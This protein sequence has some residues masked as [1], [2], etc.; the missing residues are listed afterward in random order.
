[1]VDVEKLSD[2]EL[3]DQLTKHG[4][5]PGP[6]LPS[7]R[8]V[9]EKKLLQILN[10][11]PSKPTV[12]KTTGDLELFSENDE[13]Y[14]SDS[15]LEP[16]SLEMTSEKAQEDGKVSNTIDVN[17]L[18]IEVDT[19]LTEP[20]IHGQVEMKGSNSP[21]GKMRHRFLHNKVPESTF[22]GEYELIIYTPDPR[23]PFG[24][25]PFEKKLIKEEVP[26]AQPDEPK[27]E[28]VTPP[29]QM[30]TQVA[31]EE[32]AEEPEMLIPKIEPDEGLPLAFRAA[33]FGIF[34]FVLLVYI[35]METNP[36][37]PFT[38]FLKEIR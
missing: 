18:L 12:K 17:I 19:K 23:S 3:L 5:K 10:V 30:E 16:G 38:K 33:V 9:Y 6:I 7:T 1:M 22:V 32:V 34:V 2:F 37:N 11:R 35:T 14:F 28:V 26:P 25:R 4:L 20:E 27:T 24:V 21:K 36:E 13:E 15:V 31:S 8:K 29:P